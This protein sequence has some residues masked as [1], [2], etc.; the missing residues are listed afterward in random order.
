M[1]AENEPVSPTDSGVYIAPE[2]N[3]ISFWH[4][5]NPTQRKQYIALNADIVLSSKEIRDEYPEFNMSRDQLIELLTENS[6]II[7]TLKP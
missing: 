1:S 7:L 2:E 5:L 4:S 3:F 6:E